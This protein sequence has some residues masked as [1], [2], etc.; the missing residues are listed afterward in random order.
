MNTLE[1]LLYDG[2]Y[3]VGSYADALLSVPIAASEYLCSGIKNVAYEQAPVFFTWDYTRQNSP[4]Y[5][6]RESL[7]DKLDT[8]A[9]M[10]FI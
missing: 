2:K 5:K 3:T 6:L 7:R 4:T 10:K 8:E 9:G 1:K